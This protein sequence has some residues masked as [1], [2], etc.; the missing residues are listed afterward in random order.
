MTLRER[1]TRG[2]GAVSAGAVLAVLAVPVLPAPAYAAPVPKPN[3]RQ[4]YLTDW[5][6]ER[7]VWP[8]S[9]GEGVKVAIVDTGVDDG[10]NLPEMR[11][12]VVLP[13]VDI[14]EHQEGS[15]GRYD[16]NGHGTQM[17]LLVA[18]RGTGGG[19]VGVAP[20]STILP[21]KI[22]TGVDTR[23]GIRWAADNGA[24]VI[25][26]SIA[27][28]RIGERCSPE[29]QDALNYAI[30]RDVVIVA[31][32][33]NDGNGDNN[34]EEPSSC[35]GVVAVGA[36]D[37]SGRPW[38]KTQRKPYVAVAAPGA[39]L[40]MR[41][42]YGE[43]VESN[44]TSNSA[45]LVAGLV[46]LV[47][48]RFPDASAREVVQRVIATARDTGPSGPDETTG[49]GVIDPARAL[50]EEVPADAPNPVFAAYDALREERESAERRDALLGRLPWIGGGLCLALCVGA[51]ALLIVWSVRRD[52]RAR[53]AAGG[54][55]R[56]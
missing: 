24:K 10:H 16:F 30:E 14:S 22:S 26:L 56:P 40:P 31:G 20:R 54:W 3:P 9:Q 27:H 45:A 34:T 38:E 29:M 55:G 8:V 19:A 5:Q 2:F 23:N 25:N 48:A 39:S 6:M 50:T 42:Y 4:W 53:L 46:A 17:G 28:I 1:S 33:G 49:Y 12:G 37:R 41:N 51:V 32:S 15:D 35:P 18:A 36:V 7:A 47:R 21:V 43:W 44:G 11:D 13:G 52:R